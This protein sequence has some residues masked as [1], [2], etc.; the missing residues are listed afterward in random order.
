MQR[1]SGVLGIPSL[2]AQAA[3]RIHKLDD[4]LDASDKLV[5]PSGP[6]PFDGLRRSIRVDGLVFAYKRK[7]VLDGVSLEIEA[8][9]TTYVVGATGSGKSTLFKLLV[10]LY[11]CPPG[12]ILFDGADLRELR[13]E[14][15]LERVSYCPSRPLLFDD[16]IRRNVSYGLG[17]IDEAQL[18]KAAR[19]ARV[20]DFLLSLEGKLDEVVGPRGS[21]VSTG[22]AQRLALMRL[23]L[24]RPDLVLLD[25]AT[26]GLDSATEG[27]IWRELE[28]RYAG[29]TL[30]VIAHRLSMI[31]AASRVIVMSQGRV[32]EQGERDQLLAQGGELARLWSASWREQTPAATP[33]GSTGTLAAAPARG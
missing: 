6:R 9:R 3:S 8:G 27:E 33:S 11:D 16:T 24:T 14:D 29:R 28:A 31:P 10:R 1:F 2:L 23:F 4:A 12:S 20:E 21:Q 5:V 22:E 18:W 19:Q 17:E 25:E 32:V 13:T 7:A 15:I 30:V 26:S